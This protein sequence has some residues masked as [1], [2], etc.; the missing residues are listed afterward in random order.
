MKNL[1]YKHITSFNKTTG[2][3]RKLFH[4]VKKL[5]YLCHHKT[6]YKIIRKQIN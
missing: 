4:Y 3:I 1:R 2:D 5:F 6:N